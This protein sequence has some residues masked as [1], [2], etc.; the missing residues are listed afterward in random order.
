[1]IRPCTL[2]DLPRVMEIC[3][4]ARAIM[5]A[6]GNMNQWTGGYPSEE[7][8]VKDIAS[9]WGYVV[10]SDSTPGDKNSDPNR[11]GNT[12]Q[13]VGYFAFIQGIE[14]TYL[15]IYDGSWIDD[16]LPYA[17]IHR[18]ASTRSSHGVA[19]ACFNWAW[20]RIGNL[21]IDTHRDNRIMQHCIEKAGFT[22]CGIIL[23]ENG[24]ERL[25]YQKH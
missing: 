5:R 17:T 12:G 11:S 20:E 21:R 16:V 19:E 14:K 9:G 25:A 23:L 15:K 22:Y 13:I 3:D 6:D 4:E 10:E 2:E 7:S 8:I 1:M 18:L 24:D